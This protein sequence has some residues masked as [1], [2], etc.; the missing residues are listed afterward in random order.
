M[1]VPQVPISVGELIDKLT[2]LEIKAAR[3]NDPLKLENISHELVLLEAV[4]GRTGL[5]ENHALRLLKAELALVNE[6]LWDIEDQIRELE[7]RQDFGTEFVQLARSVY[8]TNDSRA[9]LKRQIN[10]TMGSTLVEE[11]SYAS[12]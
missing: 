1:L 11:K 10:R 3:I 7:R 9:E 5:L 2:I 12:Y 6:K 8:R 4:V